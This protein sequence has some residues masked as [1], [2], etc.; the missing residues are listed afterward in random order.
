MSELLRLHNPVRPYD[1]GSHTVL[2]DLLGRPSPTA[3]PEAELWIG[4]HPGAPSIL[5]DGRSLLTAVTDA[6]RPMIGPGTDRLPF[7][8]KVLAVERPLSIQ[9]HPDAGQARDGYERDERTGLAPGD[10]KR[11]Y[12]DSWPKPEL[13]YALTAFE[14][15][16]G[17]AEPEQAASL[18]TSTGGTRL[19]R[20]ADV[21]VS[22]GPCAAVTLLGRW[23]EDDRAA[24]VDEVRTS[25]ADIPELVWA[26]RLAEL[27][28]DDPGVVTSLLM[29]L[30][31]LA[32]GQALFARPRTLHAYLRG[33]GVEIMAN[34]DNVLR[35]G[36]TAKHIDLAELQAV[37]D[38]APSTPEVVQA[39]ELPNGEDLYPTPA[40]QFQLTRIRGDVKVR[41]PGPGA[42]LCIEGELTAERGSARE[43]LR[44][45]EVLFVPATGGP[46]RVTG[47]G[48]AFR[49]SIPS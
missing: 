41:A 4:A 23:P 3:G 19:R 33:T 1:W 37:T 6:P 39:V 7:L 11:S 42:L 34:S 45:G 18:L 46:L 17:F 20:V 49:A 12:H 32:P 48:L 14:A 43:T 21:L 22:G 36:L 35:G 8:L 38:F 44:R 2:A 30:V 31:T 16:C 28:P 26:R 24:L 15:L 29:N 10:P 47:S 40:A 27:Y 13:L 25:R 9:V 5:P